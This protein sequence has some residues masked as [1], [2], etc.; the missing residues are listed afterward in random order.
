MKHSCHVW[1]G[2]PSCY[3]DMSDKLQKQIYKPAN[4]FSICITLVDVNLN[5]LN[6]FYFFILMAGSFVI[7][8]GC[9]VFPPPFLDVKRIILLDSG[10][11]CLQI[12]FL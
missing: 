1:A 8:I 2:A 12:A 5:W 10:F 7:L 3:L 9:M 11:F 6:C 4:V